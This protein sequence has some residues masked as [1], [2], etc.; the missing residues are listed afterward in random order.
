M[1]GL[2]STLLYIEGFISNIYHNSITKINYDA[3][4]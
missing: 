1:L 3:S 2:F 4:I